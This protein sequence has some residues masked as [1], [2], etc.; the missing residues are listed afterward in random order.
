M[1]KKKAQREDSQAGRGP[2]PHESAVWLAAFVGRDLAALS[3][4]E[5]LD[6]MH[7]VNR[8][9]WPF[10]VGFPEFDRVLGDLQAELRAA[11][12]SLER[13]HSWSLPRPIIRTLY[14]LQASTLDR[15]VRAVWAQGGPA[16]LR[17][18]PTQRAAFESSAPTE[19]RESAIRGA[20]YDLLAAWYPQ[21]RRCGH[22]R[23]WFLPR[24]GRQ[25]FDR[26]DCSARS[27]WERFAQGRERDYH[28]EYAARIKRVSP[29]AKPARR[30]PKGAR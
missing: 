21:L 23:A 14:R 9:L 30:G 7:G 13:D 5:H 10:E 28:A 20:A 19:Q 27:R 4:G 17:K 22:C 11:L 18:D 16:V 26:A 24:H 8:H 29:G 1:L 6:L 15:A 2:T 25:Q 12:D 3:P